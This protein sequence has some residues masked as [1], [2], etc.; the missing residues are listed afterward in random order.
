[1]QCT[2]IIRG[3]DVMGTIR[4]IHDDDF[5]VETKYGFSWYDQTQIKI[6]NNTCMLCHKPISFEV[7]KKYF[8]FQCTQRNW[9][10]L[11]MLKFILIKVFKVS[12]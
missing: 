3:L 11:K 10:A 9:E 2:V 7:S 1:M 5:L 12:H 6:V 8:C 4:K